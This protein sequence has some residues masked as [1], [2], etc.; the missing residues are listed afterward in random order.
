MDIVTIDGRPVSILGLAGNQ[1]IEQ[2][3]VSKAFNA[4]I[5]YFFFYNQNVL[6]LLDGL[7]PLLAARR[8][9]IVVATGSESRDISSIRQYIDSV[10]RNLNIDLLDVFKVEYVSPTDELSQVQALLE[11]LHV[12]KEKGLIRYVGATTHNRT[13]ALELI[14]GG[15]CD[16]LMHRYNMAHRTAEEQV[17]PAAMRAGIPVIAFT[18]TRWGT[19]LKGHPSWQQEVPSAADCYRYVLQHPAIRLALSAPQSVAQ[20][21]ENLTAMKLGALN[22]QQKALWDEYG[23]VIYGDGLSSFETQWS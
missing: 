15:R 8:T 7:K 17:L 21:N 12:W 9:E 6:N 18:A 22:L 10:R 3:C 1:K 20:L 5:N 23:Q 19:L 13:V 11:E 4:G 2:D 14:A 16:V